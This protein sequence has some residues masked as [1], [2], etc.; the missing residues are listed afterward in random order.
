MKSRK[1]LKQIL[2]I[3]DN[4]QENENKSNILFETRSNSEASESMQLEYNLHVY[5]A[6]LNQYNKKI[7]DL[8]K[9]QE[10][11]TAHNIE[12]R[13]QV[14]ELKEQLRAKEEAKK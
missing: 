3:A 13:A 7:T 6:K 10:R 14:E 1:D 4:N 5:N 9:K 2:V 8:I 11:T 12:L